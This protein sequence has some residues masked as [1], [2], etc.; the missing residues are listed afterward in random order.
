MLC[1]HCARPLRPHPPLSTSLLPLRTLTTASTSPPFSTPFTPP[2]TSTPSP[3]PTPTKPKTP[4]ATPKSSTKAGTVLKGLAYL[5]GQDP[6]IAREDAE[7]PPWL[8]GL[9][10]GKE[11]AKGGEGEE[12][13]E[14][15]LFGR[16]I[17]CVCA[18]CVGEGAR[19]MGMGSG[20]R[21]GKSEGFRGIRS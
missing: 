11:E 4:D 5:K 8:W 16:W 7:Y 20:G 14:G 6:P 18:V 2:P 21:G 13:G 12:G 17:F 10:E 1:R 9:L 3:L 15:D 19:G